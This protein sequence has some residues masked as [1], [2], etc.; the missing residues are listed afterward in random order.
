M[1]RRLAISDSRVAAGLAIDNL[2][3]I[4]AQGLRIVKGDFISG[5]PFHSAEF[6]SLHFCLDFPVFS[7]CDYYNQPANFEVLA[8]MLR[9]LV[10]RPTDWPAGWTW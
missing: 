6:C 2:K 5:R 10:D 7:R 1:T 4:Y 8:S 3:S 9:I